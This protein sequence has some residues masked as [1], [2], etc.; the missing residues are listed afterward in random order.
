MMRRSVPI[1]ARNWKDESVKNNDDDVISEVVAAAVHETWMQGRLKQ[2]WKYG[3]ER[4]DALKTN[5]CI[6]PYADLPESEKAYDRETARTVVRVLR[7]Q[8]Y[9]IVRA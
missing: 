3:P 6:I 7:E 9:L 1:V 8:G 4:N 5:P 2:G